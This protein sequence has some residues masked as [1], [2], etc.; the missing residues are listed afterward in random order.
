MDSIPAAGI[1]AQPNIVLIIADDL[2]YGDL[3]CYGATRI[4][5]PNVDRLAAEGV[6]FT[7]GYAPSSTCTPSR[8]S[9]LTG[10]YAWRQK[11]R[12]TSILDG[13][14]P[15][16]I[17]P[18]RV[19]LPSLLRQAGY[20]TGIVGKW[21]LGLGD[22]ETPV[23]F[24]GEI[25]PGPLEVGFDYCY[26]IPATVDRVPS[27]WI[28]N[29]RV[30]GLD[31]ADP[32]V[33]S[34]STNISD[35][36]TG[37][38][39][40]D[41][42]KQQADRQHSDTIINGISRIGYMKG[43]KAA[44]FKDEEL[45]TTV[46][47][48]SV[49]FIEQHRDVPFFLEVGYFEP[50]VPRVAEPP[51][52]GTSECGVRGDVIQQM[53]WETGEIMK[54]LDRLHLTENT[55]VILSSDNGAILF[56][57]YFDRSVEDLN[58]HEPTA[59]LRGWKYLVF[60]GGCRVPLIARWPARIQPRVSDQMFNLVDCMATLAAIAGQKVPKS[61]AP[62]SIDLSQVL[63]GSTDRNVRDNTVLH[64]ISDTLAI[65]QGDW[66]YIPANARA[67]AAGMGNGANPSEARFSA[68]RIPEPMLFNLA[69]DPDE[70]TNVAKQYPEQAEN[71]EA[72]LQ[73]IKNQQS[74]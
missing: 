16:C 54:A 71:L 4:K 63:L 1:P 25:K 13:D 37:L 48:K 36:P 70:T 32:I 55:L 26:I 73:A 7:Q 72:R 46:V 40:P 68:S 17:E 66:K 29:H 62:D 47:S 23:D 28:E 38:E 18:G 50:H 19:T 49:E 31:P 58:G 2:G 74:K 33:V 61:S 27:V 22:G 9:L 14:A 69:K 43:G 67:K 65:R 60:E 10:E 35:E 56:D 42:L 5:T 51:F 3:G 15:L 44:R 45:A 34:Y 41:L 64:G 11:A 39:R 12:R 30:V 21:H 53:D 20:K 8:Y 6:R 52:V 57:G 59:G 24:N